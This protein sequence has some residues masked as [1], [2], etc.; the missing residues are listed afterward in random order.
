MN[1]QTDRAQYHLI[2]NIS[3]VN[4]VMMRTG[5]TNAEG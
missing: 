3:H 4:G 2:E 1:N 5:K